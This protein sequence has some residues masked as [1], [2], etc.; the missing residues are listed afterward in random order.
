MEKRLASWKPL[1]PSP[2]L[3]TRLFGSA[4]RQT[5]RSAETASAL[6]RWLGWGVPSLGT[7]FLVASL[8][9]QPVTPA[10]SLP[11]IQAGQLAAL[12]SASEQSSQ[13]SLPFRSIAWTNSAHP[14][15]TNVSWV[16]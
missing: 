1:P 4:L 5:R 8:W 15:S 14:R 11:G 9:I 10:N 12:R 13:N 7:A 2:G 3:E 6:A 16:N